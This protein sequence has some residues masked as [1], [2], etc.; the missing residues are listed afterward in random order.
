MTIEQAAN[1]W[2]VDE[3]AGALKS[4]CGDV[5]EMIGVVGL[6]AM[7]QEALVE[8]AER[9]SRSEPEPGQPQPTPLASEPGWTLQGAANG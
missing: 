2:I 5:R 6:W 7:R 1:G 4:L 8:G 3:G 9:S